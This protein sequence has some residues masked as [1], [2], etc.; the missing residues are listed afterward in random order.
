[1]AERIIIPLDGS[2]MGEAALRY[3]EQTLVRS[4]P[5][6]M[7][8]ITLLQVISPT[9]LRVPGRGGLVD[10]FGDPKDVQEIKDLAMNYLDKAGERLRKKGATV[11]CK[12]MLGK[13]GISSA[14]SIIEAEE[15]L[16]ADL[17]AMSTHGRRGL[18]RWTLGSVTEKVL[19]SG[20]VPVLMVRVKKEDM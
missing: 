7:P 18:S 4:K 19:R 17:V 20:S 13:G 14:V 6:E 11:N 16:N 10:V 5:R 9:V 12:V 15:E 2:K 3:I 1:M 8:D